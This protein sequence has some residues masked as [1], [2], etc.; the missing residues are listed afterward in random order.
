LFGIF[1]SKHVISVMQ[2]MDKGVTEVLKHHLWTQFVGRMPWLIKVNPGTKN[3][4]NFKLYMLDAAS[5]D[6]ISTAVITIVS[7]KLRFGSS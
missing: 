4:N 5:W 7:E 1:A 3:L 6:L 2:P